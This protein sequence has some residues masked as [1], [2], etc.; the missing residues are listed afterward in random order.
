MNK[1]LILIGENNQ[2]ILLYLEPS[3]HIL[4]LTFEQNAK[5]WDKIWI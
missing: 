3:C 1:W 4:V 5:I 2:N